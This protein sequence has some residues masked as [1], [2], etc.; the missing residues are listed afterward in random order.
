MI[1]PKTAEAL[2]V[3]K[4]KPINKDK[5]T[6]TWYG[7]MG[8]VKR[9]QYVRENYRV[10]V[11]MPDTQVQ[12]AA[13]SIFVKEYAPLIMPRLYKGY[14]NLFTWYVEEATCTNPDKEDTTLV[15][16]PRQKLLEYIEARELPVEPE[17]Y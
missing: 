7:E 14:Q 6:I 15:M 10:R 16:M 1:M 12:R 4:Q 17:L 5:W 9:T 11:V 3:K 8:C 13:R 2:P